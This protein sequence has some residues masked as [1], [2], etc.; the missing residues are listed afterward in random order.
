MKF[1][2]GLSWTATF[3]QLTLRLSWGVIAVTFAYILH[4]TPVEIGT[5]LF[6]FYAGYTGSSIIWGMFIDRV[7]PKKS[8]FISALLSG[9]FIPFFILVRSIYGLVIILC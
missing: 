2:L 4:M 1:P 7:G 8:I 9:I 5:V 3:L 6:L